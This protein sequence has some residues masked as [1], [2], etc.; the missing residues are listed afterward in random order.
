MHH[1]IHP[2]H[3]TFLSDLELLRCSYVCEGVGCLLVC[4]YNTA[5]GSSVT[6]D[7]SSSANLTQLDAILSIVNE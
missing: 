3:H 6:N 5:V 7:C 4:V 2:Y 1:T